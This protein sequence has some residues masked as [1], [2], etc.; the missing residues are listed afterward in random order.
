[1]ERYIL[2]EV[3]REPFSWRSPDGEWHDFAP[4]DVDGPPLAHDEG[5]PVLRLAEEYARRGRAVYTKE[6]LKTVRRAVRSLERKGQVRTGYRQV[7]G[8]D[9]RR[10]RM[11]LVGPPWADDLRAAPPSSPRRTA[12]DVERVGYWGRCSQCGTK[13][14]PIPEPERYVPHRPDVLLDGLCLTCWFDRHPDHCRRCRSKISS[15]VGN[16]SPEAGRCRSCW[17]WANQNF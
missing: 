8:A 5:L 12:P 16:L 17:D 9:G 7:F 10:H 1:V 15:R 2:E 6:I 4:W 14:T 3:V 11:L 13:V